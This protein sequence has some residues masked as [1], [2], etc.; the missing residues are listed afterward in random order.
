MRE[1]PPPHFPKWTKRRPRGRRFLFEVASLLPELQREVAG[2]AERRQQRDGGEPAAA[3]QE[4]R[5]ERAAGQHE[6]RDVPQ[7]VLQL[8]EVKRNQVVVRTHPPKKKRGRQ[9]TGPSS[10]EAEGFDAY[11]IPPMS[12]MPPPIAAPAFSG[13][14]AT[15]ASVVRMFFAIDAAFCSA[16][17]VTMVGSPIPDLRRSSTSPVSTFRPKP[18]FAWRTC[19][20]AIEPSRPAFVASWRSGSSSERRMIFAPVASSPSSDARTS[21]RTASAALMSATPPPGA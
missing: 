14:S 8:R 19:S 15:I 9:A 17:R 4:Q 21:S 12:G 2:D 7:H 11:I 13:A 1:Y 6:R 20:T 16:E 18:A 5:A 3:D 10:N